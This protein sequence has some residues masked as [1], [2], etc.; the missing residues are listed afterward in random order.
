[1]T[2][3]RFDT[4]WAAEL[5]EAGRAV[6]FPATP[7]FTSNVLAAVRREPARPRSALGWAPRFAVAA[8]LALL[9]LTATIAI[10]SARTAV[11]EFF[12]L[13]EGERI[14]VLPTPRP[15]ASATVLPTPPPLASLG[16]PFTLDEIAGIVG[17]EP[18]LAGGEAP[19]AVF[20]VDYEG[21]SIA[22]LQYEE[23]DLWQT[24]DT[25]FGYF[26]KSVPTANVIATPRIGEDF[27]YWIAGGG[28]VVR[29]ID[30]SGDEVIGSERTIDRNTLIWLS[31]GS[32][33]F[34]RLETTADLEEAIALAVTLP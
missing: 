32:G 5:D 16:A 34:Y 6:A 1:M 24:R 29:F 12:G 21:T 22:V 2:S 11:G 14:E 33:V 19:D 9:V 27:G 26:G 10:P 25:G 28:Y 23:Y 4:R 7:E 31:R 8:V 18:A 15:G 30:A 17:F 13:V 20:L 3:E